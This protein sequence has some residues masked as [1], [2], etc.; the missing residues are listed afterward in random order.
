[1]VVFALTGAA[2]ERAFASRKNDGL[3]AAI[4]KA[5][6]KRVWVPA[7]SSTRANDGLGPLFN[8]RSC[9]QCHA[10]ATAGKIVTDDDGRLADR[11]AV[12][13]LS[14]PDGAGDAHYGS[15]VQTRAIQG[16]QAE[17]SV[18]IAWAEQRET[19]DDGSEVM[20]RRP[21]VRLERPAFG[22]LSSDIE[23]TLLLAPSL[24]VAARI[25]AVDG[26]ALMAADRPE[27]PGR[28]SRD[29]KGR[30][31]VFGR[32]ASESDLEH[33]TSLAFL[34]DLGLSTVTHPIPAGDCTGVQSACIGALHGALDGEAEIGPQIVAAI[35]HYITSLD[36]RD[37]GPAPGAAGA[38]LFSNAGC[39]ACHQPALP[40]RD[41]APVALYSDLRLHDLGASLSGLTE[42]GGQARGEWRTAP[43]I[44]VA[45][46][47]AAG[48]SLLHDGRAR[49][50]AEAVLWHGG[51]ARDAR[52]SYKALSK[53]DRS[54]LEAFVLSR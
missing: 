9:R 22:S 33:M 32:K 44:G 42:A 6:F 27:T 31:R 2:G 51:D 11:G 20:L 50:I 40:G 46:R 10:A 48:V 1:M 24:E 21:L 18:R 13:R 52:N 5:L 16:Y 23:L 30:V 3:N 45:Q 4:G 49:S 7:P 28:L 54:A 38:Q 29:D 36:T 34:R 12:V 25:A 47:L 8:G 41:G 15:Q 53:D 43:L 19:F 17:A 35:A 39:A 26:A 14:G 37:G